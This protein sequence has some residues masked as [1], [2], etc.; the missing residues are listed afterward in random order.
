[1]WS[2]VVRCVPFPLTFVLRVA[3]PARAVSSLFWSAHRGQHNNN[4]TT[5]KKRVSSIFVGGQALTHRVHR[6]CTLLRAAFEASAL[7]TSFRGDGFSQNRVC[8]CFGK[9]RRCQNVVLTSHGVSGAK[10][11]ETL[12]PRRGVGVAR[13]LA[14]NDVYLSSL[15]EVHRV[16]ANEQLR[17]PEFG[18]LTHSR[19][20]CR[21]LFEAFRSVPSHPLAPPTAGKSGAR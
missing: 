5:A 10:S 4:F 19:R 21:K 16:G 6:A 18:A 11:I 7:A 20:M 9:R 8:V 3:P 14:I 13:P 1:V 12:P 17:L 2:V 15:L